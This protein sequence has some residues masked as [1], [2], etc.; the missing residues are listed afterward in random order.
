MLDPD[1]YWEK[2]RRITPNEVAPFI[3]PTEPLWVDGYSSNNGQ[4]DRI[5]LSIAN[6]LGSSLRFIR[7]DRL[8]L[9]VSQ[10]GADYGNRRRSVQGRF[11]Y[12]GTDYWLRVTDP[13]FERKY[14]QMPNGEYP[15]GECF[16]TASLGEPFHG[17]SYKLIAAI[18]ER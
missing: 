8:E 14:L 17:H 12:G 3:D 15:I 7:V 13:I 6:S 2:I 11:Q 1:N 4:N 18:I 5:P 10:P 16:I 9:A